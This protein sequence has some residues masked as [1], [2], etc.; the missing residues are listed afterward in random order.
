MS[1]LVGTARVHCLIR[2]GP[3]RGPVCIF[4]CLNHKW[5]S[6]GNYNFFKNQA[7]NDDVRVQVRGA[8]L[9]APPTE[10]PVRTRFTARQSDG[11]GRKYVIFVAGVKSWDDFDSIITIHYIHVCR[12]SYI[13]LA[14]FIAL[15]Q[16][17]YT[18]ESE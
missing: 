16:A 15:K 3:Q 2:N 7:N 11:T 5:Y 10:Q 17:W 6:L 14:I 18:F 12:L 8:S 9:Q 4:Y 1:G 13:L